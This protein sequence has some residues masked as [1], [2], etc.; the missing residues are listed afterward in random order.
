MFYVHCT[1][2][3]REDLQAQRIA[4][5]Q[6]FKVEYY[7]CFF[8]INITYDYSFM[9]NIVTRYVTWTYKCSNQV[10]FHNLNLCFGT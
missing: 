9:Y 8:L 3:H 10:L 2:V 6:V 7:L 5:E 1:D 4:Q